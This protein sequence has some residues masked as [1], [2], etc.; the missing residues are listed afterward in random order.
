[1]SISINSIVDIYKEFKTLGSGTFSEVFLGKRM[2]DG[3]KVVL[4][5]LFKGYQRYINREIQILSHL[6]NNNTHNNNIV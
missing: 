3:K 4:K 1:M 2:T 5:K 6:R